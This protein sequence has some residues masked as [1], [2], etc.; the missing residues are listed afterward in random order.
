MFG[1]MPEP[2]TPAAC[3]QVF[4]RTG[5]LLRDAFTEAHRLGVKTCVGTE[6]PLK[7]PRQVAER[8]RAQGKD[9][10]DRAVV[11]ELYERHLPPDH[12]GLS[13]RFL[14]VLDTRRMD[15]GGQQAGRYRRH[16]Q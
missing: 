13:G 8:L 1:A 16:D 6:T 4:E 2:S 3:N 10:K 15:V 11:R 12:P 14:L 9:L 7:V 5:A